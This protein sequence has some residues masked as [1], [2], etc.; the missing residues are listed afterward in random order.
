[1]K[2]ILAFGIAFMLAISYSLAAFAEATGTTGATGKINLEQT[3]DYN[4][5]LVVSEMA[6]IMLTNSKSMSNLPFVFTADCEREI[7]NS[8]N[9]ANARNIISTVIDTIAVENSS[10]K[11]FVIMGNVKVEVENNR[12]N[13]Y[14]LELHVNKYGEVYGFNIW[15]Y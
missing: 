11:D 10:N 12:N 4:R 8:L 3:S 9:V 1:M 5:A 7:K 6:K 15:G 13:I 14:I 2:K